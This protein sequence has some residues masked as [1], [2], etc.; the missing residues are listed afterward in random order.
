MPAC[1]TCRYV[2]LNAFNVLHVPQPHFNAPYHSTIYFLVLINTLNCC[3]PLSNAH[4][5]QKLVEI[6]IRQ[7]CRDFHP[8]L[9]LYFMFLYYSCIWGQL[10]N[11]PKINAGF[12]VD[13]P[14]SACSHVR[15]Q[16]LQVK[17]KNCSVFLW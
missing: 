12:L 5:T 13:F 8:M 1:I 11:Q 10:K 15:K 17:D 2:R 3:D 6:H 14:M 9:Q 16:Q 7:S 4:S